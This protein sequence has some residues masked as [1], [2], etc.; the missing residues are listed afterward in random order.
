[1]LSGNALY[2]KVGLKSIYRWIYESK[3]NSNNLAVLR[4]KGKKR[5]GVEKREIFSSPMLMYF[6]KEEVMKM[7][8]GFLGS[9][10]LSKPIYQK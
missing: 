8:M 5:K 2:K 1:M 6:G 10:T 9:F 3:I 4:H 7:A